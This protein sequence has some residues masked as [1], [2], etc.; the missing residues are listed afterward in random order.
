MKRLYLLLTVLG[1]VVPYGA[2]YPWF[3]ENGF[4]LPLL[5]TDAFSGPISS[6]AWLDV[7]IAAITLVC[8]IF[9]DAKR[10]QVGWYP[11]AVIATFTI[12]VSAGLP[13][14]LYLRELAKEKQLVGVTHA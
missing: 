6:F 8:F 11:L 12:G 5:L 14:Y 4:N 13:L 9:A 10:H 7:V 1:T 2:S 3:V